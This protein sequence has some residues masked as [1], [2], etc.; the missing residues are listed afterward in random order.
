MMTKHWLSKHQLIQTESRDYWPATIS[1]C[2][3]TSKLL[4]LKLRR[5]L[6]LVIELNSKLLVNDL[7]RHF[8]TKI[9]GSCDYSM[10]TARTLAER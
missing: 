2:H 1:S 3:G 7:M 5:L 10:A 8:V 9:E 4:R 6:D